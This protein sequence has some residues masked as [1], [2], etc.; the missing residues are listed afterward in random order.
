MKAQ[1]SRDSHRRTK[2]YSGVYQQQGRML[3]DADWNELVDIIKCRQQK[4][5]GMTVDSGVPRDDG[6]LLITETRSGPDEVIRDVTIK[7]ELQWGTVVVDGIVGEVRGGENAGD[8]FDYTKQRFFQKAPSLP[9]A[10]RP[11]PGRA[12]IIMRPLADYTLYA[13]VWERLVVSIQDDGLRDPALHGADTCV[14]TQ[15]MAQI[16]YCDDWPF[17]DNRDRNPSKGNAL[18]DLTYADNRVDEDDT[19]ATETSIAS[20]L[21]NY[22]FRLEVHEV[23]GEKPNYPTKVTLKWSSENGAEAH[24]TD[25]VPEEFKDDKWIYEFFSDTT[26][27]H[28]GVHFDKDNIRRS[29]LELGE[30]P[31]DIPKETETSDESFPYV[32]RWDGYCVINRTDVGWELG[33]NKHG[34]SSPIESASIGSDGI[35][36]LPIDDLELTLEIE[37]KT[38][39]AGDYWL[40]LLRQHGSGGSAVDVPSNEPVGI[41]HHYLKLL[42]TDTDPNSVY[43]RGPDDARRLSFPPLTNLTAERIGYY[44]VRTGG[45]WED[46]NDEFPEL[47]PQTVQDAID[48]LAANVEASDIKYELPVCADVEDDD[49]LSVGEILNSIEEWGNRA[50][51]KV[52]VL[53]D[54][55][56]CKLDA[57]TVP[58]VISG[59]D[60]LFDVILNKKTGG[61]ITGDLT[62]TG[63]LGIGTPTPDWRLDVEFQPPTNYI[64]PVA[65]FKT[66]GSTQSVGAI[67][68]QN[69]SGNHFN[70]GITGGNAFAIGAFNNNISLPGDFLRITDDGKV[71]IG[72][73]SPGGK[74]TVSDSTVGV[75]GIEFLGGGVNSAIPWS[76]GEVYLTGDRRNGATGTGDFHYRTYDGT[77]Y[78]THFLVK[79]D[80]GSV[81]VGGDCT[82]AGDLTVNGTTTTINTAELEVE[83][84]IIRVNK[85]A[86]QPTPKDIDAGLEVYRGGT[87]KNAQLLWDEGDKRWVFGLEGDYA[88]IADGNHGHSELHTPGASPTTALTVDPTGNVGIGTPA[89]Q[90]KL[91]IEGP[92]WPGSF[93]YLSS[94]NGGD[95]GDAGLRLMRDDAAKWH[96]YNSRDS[97]GLKDVLRIAPAKFQDAWV[98]T[99]QGHVG[100]GT[101]TPDAGARLHVNGNLRVDGEITATTMQY[102]ETQIGSPTAVGRLTIYGPE[103]TSTVDGGLVVKSGT[104]TS[105]LKVDN[106]E[107]ECLGSTLFLNFY[108]KRKVT[109]GSAPTGAGGMYVYGNLH[110]TGNITAGGS[111]TGYVTDRFLNQTGDAVEQGDVVVLRQRAA[112][113][114][115]GE[116]DNIPVPEVDLTTKAYDQR[117]CGIVSEVLIEEEETTPQGEQETDAGEPGAGPGARGAG[118]E[119]AAAEAGNPATRRPRGAARSA[120]GPRVG[121]DGVKRLQIF[122]A[123]QIKT[124][125]KKRVGPGQFGHM[126]TLGCFAH[127]KVDASFGAIRVGDL[128]TTSPTKG[129]A[130]KVDDRE[131]ALGAIIGKALGELRSGQGKIPVLL[132]L[133]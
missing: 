80:T 38:F 81:S 26:E 16:K 72:T 100:I 14:R 60:T 32:R 132:M 21:G 101:P 4:A 130:Q 85:Y 45:R 116:D 23:V 53:L 18:F 47:R 65:I 96:I 8:N 92:G 126:V 31:S 115:V 35:L 121:R 33:E 63:N 44:P 109:V 98:V 78:T 66:T 30:Y 102:G 107:L 83:D 9:G 5:L 94:K 50:S 43:P 58:Y 49:G 76:D 59:D 7:A 39:V 128:L 15:V 87:A 41:V 64:N 2:D 24:K 77:S 104:Q 69:T 29:K 112:E 120:R 27:Q 113:I 55:L 56:L 79:G 51:L 103:Q 97:G 106:N 42:T 131:K 122:S 84:N 3:T 40:A 1:L 89:P 57:N 93:L 125:D 25:N 118:A 90:S 68:F 95:N 108:S 86:P 61:A 99:Q 127:C 123:E 111:K 119:G 71:G 46:I 28:L 11:L 52:K 110:A 114:H 117:V 22:L 75:R 48:Q 19:C 82:I 37:N 91:H 10:G 129:H 13:D 105:Y 62:I 70:I 34:S 124:L 88:P 133:Q 74:L 6:V 73:E 67:R 36:R 20:D 54:A 17:V 12:S